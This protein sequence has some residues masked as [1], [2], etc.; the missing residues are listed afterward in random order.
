MSAAEVTRGRPFDD[1]DKGQR[2]IALGFRRFRVIWHADDGVGGNF[3]IFLNN[4][5][6]LLSP[7]ASHPEHPRGG[8]PAAIAHLVCAL[9]AAWTLA[10][11]VET[12]AFG[13]HLGAAIFVCGVLLTLW[14]LLVDV[15][16]LA[17]SAPW[18]WTDTGAA[19]AAATTRRARTAA[20]ASRSR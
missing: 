18:P 19:A 10:I 14:A 4:H 13:A 15:L 11:L 1:E 9:L 2:A 12:G 6:V 7:F 8:T 16:A 5:H 17:L 20:T 3:V